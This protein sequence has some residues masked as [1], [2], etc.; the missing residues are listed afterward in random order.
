[1]GTKYS[2]IVILLASLSSIAITTDTRAMTEG[3]YFGLAVGRGNIFSAKTSPFQSNVMQ[4]ND[5]GV[6]ERAYFGYLFH[7]NTMKNWLLGPELGYSSYPSNTYNFNGISGEDP[8]YYTA[9]QTGYG[10]DIILNIT[11]NLTNKINIMV[12]PGVQYAREKFTYSNTHGDNGD[13]QKKIFLPEINLETNWQI[14]PRA[15]LFL[16]VAYQYITGN[17]GQNNIANLVWGSKINVS[18]RNML[19]VNCEYLF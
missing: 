2:R 1:M 14:S 6:A 13:C 5:G 11:Y 16:G 8:F 17:D 15:P 10:D 4:S 7:N 19:T 12:K 9:K 3:P 18:S